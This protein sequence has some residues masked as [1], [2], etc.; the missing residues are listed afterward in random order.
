M[1]FAVNR[2]SL[3]LL[4]ILTDPPPIP[5]ASTE[6]LPF[7]LPPFEMRSVWVF[8]L[9]GLDELLALTRTLGVSLELSESPYWSGNSLSDPGNRLFGISL[10]DDPNYQIPPQDRP[11]AIIRGGGTTAR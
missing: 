4:P 6:A 3:N 2:Y 9:T 1:K 7:G 10:I 5:G 8:E 11:V